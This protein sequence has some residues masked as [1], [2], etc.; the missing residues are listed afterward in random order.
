MQ[1]THAPLVQTADAIAID[2]TK[3]TIDEVLEQMLRT[4]RQKEVNN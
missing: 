3:M 1:R 2:S 4:I